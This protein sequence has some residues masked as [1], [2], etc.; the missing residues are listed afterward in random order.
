[1]H[2]MNTHHKQPFSDYFL[3][4]MMDVALLACGCYVSSQLL[5]VS[6]HEEAQ[7]IPCLRFKV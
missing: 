1:M 6:H 3:S 4:V 2:N 5:C 7:S